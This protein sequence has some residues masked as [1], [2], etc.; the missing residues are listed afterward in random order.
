[1]ALTWPDR[2]VQTV[3]GRERKGRGGAGQGGLL[4]GTVLGRGWA[5]LAWLGRGWP[6]PFFLNSFLL[7]KNSRNS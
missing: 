1:M 2:W 3:S 5:G 7:F 4:P 6:F